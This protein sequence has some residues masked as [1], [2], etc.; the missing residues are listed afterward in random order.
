M[1][2]GRIRFFLFIIYFHLLLRCLFLC[3]LGP[4]LQVFETDV[5][6]AYWKLVGLILLKTASS[7]LI[8]FTLGFSSGGSLKE[9]WR[10]QTLYRLPWTEC[11]APPRCL[12]HA[13]DTGHPGVTTRSHCLQY[14]EVVI[15]SWRFRRQL[16]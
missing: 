1:D 15:D 3:Q 7:P 8:Y 6:L 9:G 16:L 5:K 2:N 4:F 10:I 12:A 14:S 13:P 11:Q